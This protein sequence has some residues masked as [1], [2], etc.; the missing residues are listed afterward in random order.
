MI[1]KKKKCVLNNISAV[2]LDFEHEYTCYDGLFI[3][4]ILCCLL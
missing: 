2:F 4:I 3:D 1:P